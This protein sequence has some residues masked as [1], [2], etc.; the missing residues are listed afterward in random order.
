MDATTAIQCWTLFVTDDMLQDVVEYTNDE[1]Q[2]N[3]LYALT[4]IL[5]YYDTSLSEL[6][7]SVSLQ[8]FLIVIA[9]M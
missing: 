5:V 1:V 2:I 6:E 7:V 9:G 8:S 3:L 4:V